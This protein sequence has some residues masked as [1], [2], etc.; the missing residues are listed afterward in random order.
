MVEDLRTAFEELVT[1]AEW[2]DADTQVKLH[3]IILN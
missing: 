2:M 1:E 3:E